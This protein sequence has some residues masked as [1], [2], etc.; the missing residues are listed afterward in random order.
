MEILGSSPRMT[1]ET[2]SGALDAYPDAYADKPGHD[3]V[4][5]RL[6]PL[7]EPEDDGDEFRYSH[8]GIDPALKA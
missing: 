5:R 3:E 6:H 7:V 1:P 4:G 8:T 2:K